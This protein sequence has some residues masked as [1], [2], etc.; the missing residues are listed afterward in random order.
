M[1]NI[2]LGAGIFV[3]GLTLLA[4]MDVHKRLE[5]IRR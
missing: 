3:G 2:A 5:R 1:R 4:A